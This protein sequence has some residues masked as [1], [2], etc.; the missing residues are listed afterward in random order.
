MRR[1][2]FLKTTSTLLAA[3]TLPTIPALAAETPSQGRTVLPMNRGW[4]YH[5]DKVEGAEAR[6]L[7]RRLFRIRRHSPH[8]HRAALAQLR[9]QDYEFVSTY[10]RRFKLPAAAAG[11]RVFVDFEGAMTASTVWINGVRLGEYKGGYTPFSFELTPHLQPGRRKRSRRSGRLH[12][13]RRHPALRLRDRLP[14]LRRHLSRG[15]PAHRPAN[16]H[17]QHLRPPQRCPQRQ[18]LARRRLLPRRRAA[19]GRPHSLEVELRDGDRIVA[20]ATSSSAHSLGTDPDAAADPDHR[21]PSLRQHRDHPRSRT[22]HC[23]TRPP[24]RH[25]ALG[26]RAP[27]SLHRPRPPAAERPRSSTATRAAS[28]SAK[29]RSPTT[30]SRSTERSSSCAASTAIR[31]FPSSARPCRRACSARTPTSCARTCTATSS[32]P[33]T[34]RSRATSS[35]LRRDRPAGARRDSRLAA[36]RR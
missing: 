34:I 23:L 4:R 15:L 35:T 8:Q 28:A 12:R 19:A 11:K 10:R 21:R 6:H 32:A 30:A 14:H 2:D 20:K 1:R 26:S 16:L 17:R 31:P 22:P 29:P 24:R 3:T 9:R 5:P 13:A 7:Q 25:Q 33:R 36:H 27:A 18:S